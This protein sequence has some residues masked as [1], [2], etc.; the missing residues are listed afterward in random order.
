MQFLNPTCS[1]NAPPHVYL[2]GAVGIEYM[3]IYTMWTKCVGVPSIHMHR[4]DDITTY[5][6]RSSWRKGC[7]DHFLVSKCDERKGIIIL[8][9]KRVRHWH[10]HVGTGGWWPRGGVIGGRP[11][12]RH[13]NNNQTGTS[14][15]ESCYIRHIF[16]LN[17]V[18]SWYSQQTKMDVQ[19]MDERSRL[20]SKHWQPVPDILM[21][22]MLTYGNTKIP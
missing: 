22:S 4:A 10:R 11:F 12:G 3:C 19:L 20:S 9:A 7:R 6:E 13:G 21:L 5:F 15:N 16:D 18:D 17:F 8:Q 14:L 2:S 1:T